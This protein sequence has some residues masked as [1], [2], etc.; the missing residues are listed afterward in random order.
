VNEI[1]DIINILI[2]N[3][4]SD[5]NDS[6]LIVNIYDPEMQLIKRLGERTNFVIKFKA[7]IQGMYSI[8][9]IN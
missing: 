3:M 5:L 9:I 7:T 6:N 2:F 4:N 1:P 8:E